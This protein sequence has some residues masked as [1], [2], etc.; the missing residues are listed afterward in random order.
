MIVTIKGGL[1]ELR[2]EKKKSDFFLLYK[3]ILDKNIVRYSNVSMGN[4]A[5]FIDT[6]YGKDNWPKLRS[7]LRTEI[8]LG[9][10]NNVNIIISCGLAKGLNSKEYNVEIIERTKLKQYKKKAIKDYNMVFA[11]KDF[12]DWYKDILKYEYL[13]KSKGLD[14]LVTLCNEMG[15]VSILS[16]KNKINLEYLIYVIEEKKDV[17]RLQMYD[18]LFSKVMF[19]NENE[20]C[21][22]V[23]VKS[24]ES[25]CK[26][27]FNMKRNLTLAGREQVDNDLNLLESTYRIYKSLY[28]KGE[29][30]YCDF[31]FRNYDKYLIK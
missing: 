6:Y 8:M 18:T 28:A 21:W 15:K 31:P 10:K 14:T 9:N 19:E 29:L 25:H 16:I 3:D 30:L 7:F 5:L 26:H 1:I 17:A 27:I 2:N 11:E 23:F 20:I 22:Y 4:F 24:Y 13:Y 12:P